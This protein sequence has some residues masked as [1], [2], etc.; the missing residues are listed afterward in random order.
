VRKLAIVLIALMGCAASKQQTQT[1]AGETPVDSIYN[2]DTPNDLANETEVTPTVNF[3]PNLMDFNIRLTE[4]TDTNIPFSTLS[5]QPL[6]IYYY[7]P[8]CP[9]CPATYPSV[10]LM[11]KE[12]ESYGLIFITISVGSADKRDILM[13]IEQY[14][15]LNATIPLFQDSYQEFS[16]K[17]GD[18]YVP[19]IYLIFPDG[20]V[21]R[22]TNAYSEGLKDIKVD[23]NR[24]LGIKKF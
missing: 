16:K 14:N 23:L 12:Y 24:L 20:K 9:H 8:Y 1:T 10:Q 13:F 3:L 15:V 5:S 19:R 22:Y 2:T 4:I 21:L 7:S 6:L 11:S 18:G 17:Y